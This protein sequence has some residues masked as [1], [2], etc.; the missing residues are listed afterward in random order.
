VIRQS[1]LLCIV[2]IAEDRMLTRS[3]LIVGSWDLAL[4]LRCVADET[5]DVGR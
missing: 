1:E 2:R 5:G 3:G 4:F